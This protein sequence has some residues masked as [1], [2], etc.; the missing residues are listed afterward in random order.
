MWSDANLGLHHTHSLI[1]P[2]CKQSSSCSWAFVCLDRSKSIW[3]FLLST[4]FIVIVIVACARSSTHLIVDCIV[5]HSDPQSIL[6][7]FSKVT[8]TLL[9]T[10][11]INSLETR[12][13]SL[14]Y[15]IVPDNLLSNVN[16]LTKAL[17]LLPEA[18]PRVVYRASKNFVS[19]W[20]ANHS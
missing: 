14:R 7:V 6:P 8:P 5:S 1:Y 9:E 13:A 4:A 15:R 12:N 11:Q 2:L 10:W 20:W 18:T 16:V 17:V 3:C 19:L